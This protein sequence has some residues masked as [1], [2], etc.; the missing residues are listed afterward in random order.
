MDD[1]T[2]DGAGPQLPRQILRVL[3]V[4]L[5]IWA[6]MTSVS[7]LRLLAPF[8]ALA[9]LY[10]G[11]RLW[12]AAGR[13]PVG[14]AVRWWT[15]L[16]LCALVAGG[17]VYFAAGPADDATTLAVSIA[18]EESGVGRTVYP[19]PIV[20]A[21]SVAAVLATLAGGHA[22]WQSRAPLAERLE[23]QAA[24]ATLYRRRALPALRLLVA[25]LAGVTTGCAV[26]VVGGSFGASAQ[27]APPVA[28][29]AGLPGVTRRAEGSLWVGTPRGASRLHWAA[30]G[31]PHWEAVRRPW[32]PLP[33]NAITDIAVGPAGD[34]WFATPTGLARL[35]TGATDTRWR[36]ASSGT[37]ALPDPV[38]LAAAVDAHGVA[39]TGT[40]KG[41]AAVD[42]RG[43]GRF[44]GL[45][46]APL[47]HQVLDAVFIDNTGR[48]WAGGA[49]GVNVYEPGRVAHDPGDW[50]AG[51]NG[52][53][54]R[55]ALPAN[56]VYAIMQDSRGRMWFGAN[57]GA[58]VLNPAAGEYSLGSGDASR[59][60][61]F[62]PG[63]TPLPG[64][65]VHA[66]AEGRDGRIYFATDRG[67]AILDDRV[68]TSL[69]WTVITA[70]APGTAAT[71]ASPATPNVQG[72]P[73]SRAT[74]PQLPHAW[75]E[76]LA[77]APDGRVWIGTKG[78]L[79]VYDPS[80]PDQPLPVYRSHPI[81]RWT[82]L[83]WP[84]HAHQDP[85]DD[86]ITALAWQPSR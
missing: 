25:V 58:A 83:F 68:P 79:A 64:G 65:A 62:L 42:E 19:A 1:V 53:S 74:A 23:A 60:R 57:G 4:A 12:R 13:S 49:G 11:W 50:V 46:N 32:A 63:G 82:G 7:T 61:T 2:I 20:L 27:P 70:G 67:L 10:L 38:A 86:E 55:D 21:G 24:L 72:T 6:R 36:T 52:S 78:G 71:P 76:A 8:V 66:I 85:V 40:G 18:A 77:V 43:S 37:G 84:L 47:L 39:W 14:R 3:N 48:I 75:V 41:L 44:Y 30:D 16:T 34:V 17:A 9:L 22:W 31:T 33:S 59:W 80:R 35:Q 15:A 81:R 54:T 73:G 5:R 45:H 26:V 29:P 56:L 51:F 28:A 69:V